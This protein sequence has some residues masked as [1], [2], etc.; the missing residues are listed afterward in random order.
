MRGE[1]CSP[2]ATLFISAATFILAALFMP[3]N[4]FCDSGDPFTG[5]NGLE[6]SGGPLAG[7]DVG[8]PPVRRPSPPPCEC[9]EPG[10]PSC[11]IWP[12]ACAACWNACDGEP[13]EARRVAIGGPGFDVNL[14]NYS[15]PRGVGVFQVEYEDHFTATELLDDIVANG[16]RQVT[17]WHTGNPFDGFEPWGWTTSWG[18]D[19]CCLGTSRPPYIIIE[20]MFK[21]WT[22]PDIDVIFY[23]PQSE[24][25]TYRTDDC[26]GTDNPVLTDPPYYEITRK[27]YELFGDQPKVIVLT[28]WE[29]DWLF[30]GAACWTGDGPVSERVTY[31]ERLIRRRQADVE[32]ARR[33][34]RQE[35]GHRPRLRVMNSVVLSRYP[36]NVRESD[37]S[38]APFLA[39][40]VASLGKDGPDLIGTS[41]EM[42]GGD[43]I[44]TLDWIQEHTGYPRSRMFIAEMGDN[45]K[46]GHQVTKLHEIPLIWEW[47][48]NSV[49]V[50]MWREPW[51]RDDPR[52]NRGLW[53]LDEP[54]SEPVTWSEP[55]DGLRYLWGLMGES[56]P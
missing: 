46:S 24:A 44:A 18:L 47:G 35:L 16:F 56:R 42:R 40:V 31:L 50:W 33:E 30:H 32:R 7:S 36:E 48:I 3:C 12:D 51:C 19:L 52:L 17:I 49:Q 14:M 27:L 20:D 6:A 4:T 29:Q 34:I 21:F 45:Q 38:D 5:G 13:G 54:C 9:P 15:L 28:D 1:N 23:R 55:T 26:P 22:H 39:D 37:N 53:I 11:D 41:Y 25:W 2:G 8:S 10:T 43:V